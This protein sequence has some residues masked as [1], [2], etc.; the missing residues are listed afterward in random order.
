VREPE[1]WWWRDTFNQRSDTEF[2]ANKVVA[3]AEGRGD[4][5]GLSQK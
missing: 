4:A 3:R 5:A 1:S 2:L